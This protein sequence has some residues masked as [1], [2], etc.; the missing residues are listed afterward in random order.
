MA[1]QILSLQTRATANDADGN[2]L[3]GAKIYTYQTGTTTPLVTY[4][5]SALSVA[6]TNPIIAD[7][8]GRYGPIYTDGATAVKIVI[9]TSA[10][11]TVDTL[12]P[13]PF[14]Y[15]SQGSAS[16]IGYSPNATL[17][18]SNVQDAL[19]QVA[20]FIRGPSAAHGTVGGTA[21]A[22]TLTTPYGF[23]G[24][25]PD[26]TVVTFTPPNAN[27]GAAT[28]NVDGLGAQAITTITGATLPGGYILAGIPISLV[29]VGSGWR[30]ERYPSRGNNANGNWTR[31]ADGTQICFATVATSS[32]SVTWTYPIA[33]NG[34][35]LI[36]LGVN[37]TDDR[38]A[39]H[40]GKSATSVVVRGWT[41]I[42]GA[43]DGNI[44]V[45][46]TGRWY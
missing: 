34:S 35:P 14:V 7:A 12:D 19:D 11:V 46:A 44:D 9:T 8:A 22:I 41:T 2:P 42:G 17:T 38:G 10:D 20:A 5:T 37:S 40:S 45:V 27:T 18:E 29:K 36:T 31:Y 26:G 21:N 25:I 33:F 28:I 4:T 32:G 3:P 30:A 43:W 15:D 39:T 23:T 24:T 6:N 16:Q 13:S 1:V